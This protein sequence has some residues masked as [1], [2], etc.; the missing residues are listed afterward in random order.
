MILV[1]NMTFVVKF[2]IFFIQTG[3]G[4]PHHVDFIKS[5]QPESGEDSPQRIPCMPSFPSDKSR[6]APSLGVSAAS[7]GSIQTRSSVSSAAKESDDEK[8]VDAHG[9]L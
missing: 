6:S 3:M 2:I 1:S 4:R 7:S 5:A 9:E 8:E